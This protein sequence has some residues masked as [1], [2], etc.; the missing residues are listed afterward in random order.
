MTTTLQ[1]AISSRKPSPGTAILYLEPT[2]ERKPLLL[3]DKS[4]DK[5]VF[6]DLVL[7]DLMLPGLSGE[8]V[9][10]KI[11]GIPTIVLSAKVG[12]DNKVKLLLD[13][14]VDYVTKPLNI[15]ELLARI[16]VQLRK[17]VCANSKTPN[18]DLR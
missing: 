10:P 15:K 1:S 17:S 7:L 6:P 13:G 5:Q 16:T 18:S 3:L 8:E 14:A 2:P 12:M 4:D 11:K 9:L